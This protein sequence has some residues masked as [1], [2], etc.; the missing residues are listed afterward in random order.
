[1]VRAP[2][3]S[4]HARASI[5]DIAARA[6][7]SVTT[8]SRVLN[9][10]PDVAAA[11]RERV[12]HHVQAL[13]YIG[14]SSAR[15]LAGGRTG[16]VGIVVP[17]LRGPYF[18]A[19]VAGASEALAEHD[20]RP[21]LYITQHEHD[22]EVS[23]LGQLAHDSTDGSLFVLPAESSEELESLGRK[24]YRFVVVDSPVRLSESIPQVSAT[25]WA[26]ASAAMEHLLSLGH[27]R[28]GAIAGPPRWGASDDRLA[29][30]HSA[31]VAAGLP[32]D[33]A[34]T[35]RGD[36]TVEGGYRAAVRV[37]SLPALPTAVFAFNDNMALGFLRAARERGIAVPA[38][39]SL[40][41]FD[42]VEFAA[43]TTP[44]LTTVHQP[45]M[46][47]GRAGADLLFRLPSGR[48]A[49]APRIQLATRLVVRASTA[50]PRDGT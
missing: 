46:D 41:G 2:R 29:G 24:G 47:L 44:P 31:L 14:N 38:D 45:L 48:A 28:I 25:H 11:T 34:L 20:T 42:N 49:D 22:R 8:V 17:H 9:D 33:P 26:G 40:V 27:R 36:F 19:I 10:H 16:L 7:V 39:I 18:S 37:L 13:G 35:A 30:Y 3:P 15:A 5:Q 21:V 23:M 50:P 4:P 1:M 12:L 32:I 43:H 6:G